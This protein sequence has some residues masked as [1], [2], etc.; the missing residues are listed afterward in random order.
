[1]PAGRLGATL[2]G[3]EAT[4]P[5]RSPARPP[6]GRAPCLQ[7]ALP[8]VIFALSDVLTRVRSTIAQGDSLDS[9]SGSKKTQIPGYQ[10]DTQRHQVRMGT[11]MAE[12][13]SDTGRLLQRAGDGDGESW[14]ELLIRHEERLCRMV[15]FRLDQRL[16]GRIA[17]ADVLQE[18]FL[19][20][21]K[22]LAEY[23]RQPSLPF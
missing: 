19:E 15:A 11:I 3:P 8:P 16:R 7:V 5:P 10:S 2:P 22:R 12:D 18:A 13:R 17:P 14:G 21:S 9:R 4:T 23:V 20:A 6:A 1:M